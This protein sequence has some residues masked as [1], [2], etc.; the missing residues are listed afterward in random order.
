MRMTVAS[1]LAVLLS[2]GCNADMTITADADKEASARAEIPGAESRLAGDA[3]YQ[4]GQD[5]LAANLAREPIVTPARNVILFIA[6]GMDPTTVTAAR[7]YDGQSKGMAGEENIL[8]FET[9]PHLALAKTYNTN[10]QTPDSAGT[11]T[12]MMTGVKTKAGVINVT[13]AVP[14]GDCAAS[15]ANPAIAAGELAE[16]AGMALGVISTARLT[17]ATPATVYAHAPDRGWEADS[18]LPES[19]AACPDIARQLIDFPYGDG[20]DV[21]MGGGRRNFL[22][23]ETT[24]P[25]Y[26]FAKG[27]RDDGRD[28]TAEWSAKSGDHVYVWNQKG[29]DAL[30]ITGDSKVLGLFE[31]S[32]MQ[33]EAD[34]AEDVAGE[35]SLAE[36]TGAAIDIL[37]QDEDGF[38][39]MVE[40]GR[41]DHAHHAGNAARALQDVQAFDAAVQ[42]ALDKVDLQETLI[43][44]TADHG[45][46]LSIQGYPQRG[47]PILGLATA[48]NTDGTKGDSPSLASD[49]KPYT[50]LVYAN[51]PGSLFFGGEEDEEITRPVVTEEDAQALN[52]RQQALVPSGS[53]THGGQDVSIYAQGPKAYLIDG[54]VEQNYVFHVIEHAL[55]LNARAEA[56]AE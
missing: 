15:L 9:L 19:A 35:P 6:D 36:M 4:L 44:V 54:V 11:A 46:T 21:A 13:D 47:N 29:F 49:G 40:G 12:A 45:H 7:I 28:L 25:E 3:W 30:D 2:S 51:G 42:T 39:L 10:M 31:M 5:T 23:A 24:D 20:L 37:S 34:R 27:R 18:D 17:H 26:S 22:P 14:R 43:I 8:A 1:V 38:F 48:P 55:N 41:V 52:Y 32:H 56:G 50:T 33:Y 16:M 53:E